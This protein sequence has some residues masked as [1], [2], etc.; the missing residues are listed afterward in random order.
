MLAVAGLLEGR[1]ATTRHLDIDLLFAAG[2]HADR[3]GRK[4]RTVPVDGPWDLLDVD[5]LTWKQALTKP[6]ASTCNG[7]GLRPAWERLS[8]PRASGREPGRPVGAVLF[9]C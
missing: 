3:P 5:R 4:N 9:G 1:P 8:E 2:A 6:R 7:A